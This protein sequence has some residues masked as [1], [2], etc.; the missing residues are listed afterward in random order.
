MK[1]INITN[2]AATDTLFLFLV[3]VITTVMGM[4]VTKLLSVYFT[5][6]E[7]GLYSQVMLV[8]TTVTSLSILGLTNATN[9][10]YN[11]SKN[12]KN[13]KEYVST[14]FAI[15]LVVGLFCGLAIIFLRKNISMYFQNENL[16]NMLFIIALNPMFVN[17]MNSIR[18]CMCR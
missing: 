17:L 6:D 4:A 2:G 15:Q 12:E 7:Y 1:K 10:F 18:L 11:S 13:Q 5:L 16:K 8:S 3:Q 14:I 9:Y